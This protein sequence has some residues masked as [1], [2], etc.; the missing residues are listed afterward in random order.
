M[1]NAFVSFKNT[2][3]KKNGH[4]EIA[5]FQKIGKISARRI[6]E[7]PDKRI[8]SLESNGRF[9]VKSLT[10]HLSP[11]SPLDNVLHMALWKTNSPRR[12]NVLVW[13]LLFGHLNMSSV[14]QQKLPAGCLFPSIC[15]FCLQ[16][17]EDPSHLFFLCPYSAKCWEKL[18]S[19]F[20]MSWVS[21]KDYSET[22]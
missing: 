19:V 15:P 7:A 5:E 11:S 21:D 3:N 4:E 18:L 9:L 2:K 10:T 13:V 8:W 14:L 1:S 17:G 12:A 6:S 20:N 16:H 22:V